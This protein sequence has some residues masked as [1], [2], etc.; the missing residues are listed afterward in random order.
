MGISIGSKVPDLVLT[1]VDKTGELRSLALKDFAGKNLVLYFYPKDDTPGCT[2]E[3]CQ[4]RD[5]LPDFGRIKAEI[6]GVSRD[7]VE[8]HIK[9]IKKYDLTF[10]LASDDSGAV[11]EAFGVWVEKSMYGRKYMGIERTT[12]WIDGSGGVRQIWSK[13]KVPGHAAAVI[14]VIEAA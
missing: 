13:V 4:F 8:S 12:V 1:L 10:R 11:T 5:A 7:S 6:I 2:A 3:S 14:E 9:F